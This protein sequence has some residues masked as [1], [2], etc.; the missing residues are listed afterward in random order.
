MS[1]RDK[2]RA[3]RVAVNI[4]TVYHDQIEVDGTDA[5][6]SDLSLGGCCIRLNNPG[7]LGSEIEVQF[8]LTTAGPV[9]RAR[10]VIRWVREAAP[11]AAPG[12]ITGAMG[13][14]F[15]EIAG[16]A[17]LRLKQFIEEKA[18]AELFA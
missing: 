15:S 1:E 12:D 16:D 4:G 10:A 17:L 13:V 2:R 5:L 18:A 8:R 9:F 7:P 6:M 11:D 3:P 14:Q